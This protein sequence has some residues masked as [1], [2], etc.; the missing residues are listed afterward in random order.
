MEDWRRML[1]TL[2]TLVGAVYAVPAAALLALM[3]GA[4]PAG[5]RPTAP[6]DLLFWVLL[7]LAL[8]EFPASLVVGGRLLRADRLAAPFRD[9]TPSAALARA[10]RVI[11]T[12]ALVTASLGASIGAYGVVYLLAGG[13]AGRA[14]YFLVLAAAHAAVVAGVVARTRRQFE[15]VASRISP[16]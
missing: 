3:S 4:V 16:S 8:A 10:V 11:R 12:S 1:A 13:A 6:P 9:G 2:G 5:A 15:A 7:A 14:L